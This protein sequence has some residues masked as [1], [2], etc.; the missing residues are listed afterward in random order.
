MV[1]D[2]VDA[3]IGI[4][5]DTLGSDYRVSVAMDGASALEDIS[6]KPPDLILLDIMMPGMDGYEVCQELKSDKT[7]RDIPVI[8]L[9]A[10]TEESNE[11]KGLALGAVDYITK[12]FNTELVRSRVNN[13]LELKL[14]RDHLEELVKERTKELLLTQ[15]VT[16][17]SMGTLAEFRDSETGG[18]IKRTQN[19]VKC[20]TRY[21]QTNSKYKSILN[22]K[23]TELMYKSAPLHDIGKVGIPDHILLKPGKLTDVEFEEMKQHTVYGRNTIMISEKKLGKDSFLKC[24]RRMAFS[25]HEKWNGSG[26]P[27]GL[28]GESIPISG[29]LM[30]VA[31]VYDA[32]V[33]KRTYKP[34]FPHSKAVSTILEGKGIHF[35]PD[36]VD[37]FENRSEAFRK[38]ALEFA[39]YTEERQTLLE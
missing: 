13:H 32:L 21:L 36:I 14:H 30:A 20:L 28:I 8:F 3:N 31:D 22:S 39:D 2:D 24:A 5:V 38:I 17:E 27:Q 11:A 37:A 1:I 26:Y 16:I 23:S 18:H 33:S 29:R 35:D 4:L 10:L 15:E 34:S 25:H 12:P 9:T 6:K 7:T 19:Y